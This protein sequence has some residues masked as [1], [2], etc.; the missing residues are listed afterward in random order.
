[1]VEHAV[2]CALHQWQESVQS[3]SLLEPCSGQCLAYEPLFDYPLWTLVLASYDSPT[4][5]AR[6]AMTRPAMVM[7]WKLDREI[8]VPEIEFFTF[9]SLPSACLGVKPQFLG[10]K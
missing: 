2:G 7:E 10:L 9:I 4:S 3:W 1:M 5:D 8:V 6:C